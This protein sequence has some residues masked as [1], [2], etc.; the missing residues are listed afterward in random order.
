MNLYEI[1]ASILAA[2]DKALDLE[3]GE[4]KDDSFIELV[5]QLEM[6]RDDKIKNL[7]LWVKNLKSDIVS[8][9]EE[10]KNLQSFKEKKKNK[11]LSLEKYLSD[12]LQGNKFDG[13]NVQI[14]FRRS[15]SVVVENLDIIPESFKRVKT[16]VEPDKVSLKD[17]LKDGQV[18][19][20]AILMDN[21]S[22]TIK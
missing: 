8:L 15:Q 10:I 20:G 11:V 13:G 4:I 1:N 3:T 21:L 18:I 19:E 2:W 17:A 6:E 12:N 7:A 22:M 5:N 14:S 16:T 9:D